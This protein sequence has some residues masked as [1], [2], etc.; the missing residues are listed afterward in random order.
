MASS[1]KKSKRN[2]DPS[3]LSLYGLADIQGKGI[4]VV[5]SREI[6]MESWKPNKLL[7]HLS[8]H[9]SVYNLPEDGRKRTFERLFSQLCKSQSAMTNHVQPSLNE[10]INIFTYKTAYLLA[11]CKR[12]YTE[13][14]D[15][16]R[17]TLANFAEIFAD[18]PFANELQQEIPLSND[19]MTR[20]VSDLANDLRDQVLENFRTSPFIAIAIDESVD[21]TNV[22]QLLIYGRYISDLCVKEEI[23]ACLPLQGHTTGA[24]IY[25]AVDTFF[26]DNG[27]SW[28]K[29]VECGVDGAP[30]MFGKNKGL[31]GILSRNHPHVIVHHCLIHREALATKELSAP[32]ND[33]MSTV[34]TTVNFIKAREL[35]CRLFGQLCEAEDSSHRQLLLHTAVRWLSRGK[36]LQRVFVL[37]EEIRIF[38]EQQKHC[39]SV[40]FSDPVFICRLAVLADIFALANVLNSDMQGKQ[41]F[42]F[43][44]HD[45]IKAF[46]A[47]LNVLESQISNGNYTNFPSLSEFLA[48]SQHYF[49]SE[50]IFESKR[51]VTC[52]T[53]EY[54]SQ[55]N[56]N[57]FDRFPDVLDRNNVSAA[58]QYVQF[59][60]TCAPSDF[61][62]IS[63]LLVELQNDSIEKNNFSTASNVAKFWLSVSSKHTELQ[64]CASRVLVRIG[65]TYLCEAAFSTMLLLKNKFRSR[66]THNHLEDNLIVALCS[67]EPRYQ[68]LTR[69]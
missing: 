18:R 62:S 52:E 67:Y 45:K 12:P 14:E 29:L 5:C 46:I 47:K 40:T 4:C 51:Q 9:S 20:R 15:I 64:E 58:T 31:R 59:P 2:I 22:P 61:P 44:Q 25:N 36:T 23:L 49:R 24:D 30:S 3:Y 42:L 27:I 41:H 33:V 13:G 48:T 32:F 35:N 26:K 50:E 69:K 37:R 63:L 11:R 56:D 34:I 60:F 17:P 65:T 43:E 19:T 39:L 38:L 6:P 28:S 16:I 8:T 10:N 1:S 54:L 55:L 57:F 53:V 7:R 68:K 21:I 66:L